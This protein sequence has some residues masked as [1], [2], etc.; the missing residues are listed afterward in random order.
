VLGMSRHR[1]Q[2]LLPRARNQLKT[3][4]GV[5]L[6]ARAGRQDCPALAEMLTG[7]DGRLTVQLCKRVSQH[8]ERCAACHI[9]RHRELGEAEL[10]SPPRLPEATRSAGITVALARGADCG[11]HRC[12]GSSRCLDRQLSVSPTTITLASPSG[13]VITLTAENGPVHWTI[14]EPSSLI[15]DVTV[16]PSSGTLA[17]GKS[18]TVTVSGSASLD[19]PLSVNPGRTTVT[20]V[21]GLSL[22]SAGRG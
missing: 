12:R 8:I 13:S 22:L 9:R 18:T 10:V 3:A 19:T 16:S 7:W 15:G 5:L 4:I 17:S 11:R 6:V 1:V 2:A 21:V 14:T 20:V